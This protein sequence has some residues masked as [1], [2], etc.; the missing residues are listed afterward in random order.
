[1]M[2]EIAAL[3]EAWEKRALHQP[4]EHAYETRLCIKEL[5]EAAHASP[6]REG[7]Q[8]CDYDVEAVI[9]FG[10]GGTQF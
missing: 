9:R 10:D 6:Q 1:M 5:R 8:D 7:A 4:P 3:I 2:N